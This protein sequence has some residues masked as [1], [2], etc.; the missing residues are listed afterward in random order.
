MTSADAAPGNSRLDR[1]TRP[2]S[3]P[4]LI[5]W[6]ALAAI[7]A[8]AILLRQWI[9]LNT[10]VSWLLLAGERV[11]DGQQLY[12]DVI[13]TNPPMS[14]LAYLPAI[15]LGRL[16]G[17]E[18]HRILDGE[19]LLLALLSLWISA[20]ILRRSS[21][22]A[23]FGWPLVIWSAAV[24]T[25]MP[26]QVFG[27]REHI[28]TLTL[29]PALAVWAMRWNRETPVIWAA[30]LAGLGAGITLAFKPYF[31][32]P[33]TLCVITASIGARQWSSLLAPENII[34]GGLVAVLS[35][36]TYLSFPDY[37]T[38]IY[39]IV[40][41]VY[42]S[43]SMPLSVVLINPATMIGLISVIGVL[44]ARQQSPLNPAVWL[45]LTASIGFALVFY[46]QRRGWSYHSFPMVSLAMLAMGQAI[47]RP[48]LHLGRRSL[49]AAMGVLGL[50][51]VVGCQWFYAN[52]DVGPV[53]AAIAGLKP[54]PKIL[55]LSGEAAIGN[56]LVRNVHGTWVS[57][58]Q[59]LWIR[60]HVR[61]TRED[62]AVDAATEAR[63]NDYL[64]LERRWLIEDFRKNPPDIILIDDLRDHWGDWARADT[65]IATLLKPYHLIRTV[66]GIEVLSLSQ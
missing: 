60:E 38:L 63:L 65:E 9:P 41:D 26:L 50:T 18:P 45:A 19:M 59:H 4:R 35:V 11:L 32:I 14:V 5:P 47:L 13:E 61:L 8:V 3:L 6:F 15:M 55:M 58:Q 31:A 49:I 23:D 66:Q 64:A 34:A 25:I 44:L 20:Q 51:F 52:I 54:R 24:M 42:L 40:R 43:W 1:V 46:L 56:P 12:R 33:V 37:F 57:R 53:E 39:P 17:V 29:L 22:A 2:F 62:H 7:F 10:D 30:I 27:Q 48:C 28:A 16:I 21:L 36:W